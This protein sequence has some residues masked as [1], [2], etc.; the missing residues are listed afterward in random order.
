MAGTA[1]ASQQAISPSS[2]KNLRTVASSANLV[3]Q[4]T[5]SIHLVTEEVPSCHLPH[6]HKSQYRANTPNWANPGST[7]INAWNPASPPLCTTPLGC[8]LT[9]T[10]VTQPSYEGLPGEIDVWKLHF[11]VPF[12]DTGF[13]PISASELKTKL[14]SREAIWAAAG[15]KNV[16]YVMTD[17][18]VAKGG[19]HEACGE[20]NQA[21]ID[22]A[23]KQLSPASLARYQKFGQKL[24]VGS[25]VNTICPAGPCWIYDPLQMNKNN[26]A[27][28]VTV[29]GVYMFAGNSNPFPCGE[30]KL[31][32]CPAGFH[33]C[34]L[35]S[36]AR[37]LE[38]MMVDGLRNKMSFAQ[39]Q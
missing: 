12:S 39:K 20:I 30:G 6:V 27:N 16:S 21:A 3:V 1:L 15:V 37:A 10:S 31:L 33:Y 29:K 2:S 36:P 19:T 26:T 22:W 25:D 18:P 24:Q 23:T 8:K 9:L 14:K 11:S 4:N 35:L 34:K 38:W 28:T 13:L 17:M 7:V 32:P 5:D